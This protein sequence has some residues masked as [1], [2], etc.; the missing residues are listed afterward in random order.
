MDSEIRTIYTNGLNEDVILNFQNDTN[1]DRHL[2]K[3][4][5]YIVKMWLKQQSKWG[6]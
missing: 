1:Q 3:V 5:G 6:D 4:S 2:K